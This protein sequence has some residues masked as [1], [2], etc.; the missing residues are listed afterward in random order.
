[1]EFRIIPISTNGTGVAAVIAPLAIDNI[2]TVANEYLFYYGSTGFDGSATSPSSNDYNAIAT[3]KTALMPGNTGSFNNVSS[4]YDGIN[5]ILVDFS[6]LPSDASLSAADF[7]FNVDSLLAPNAW[8]AAPAPTSVVTWTGPNGDTFADM[9]WAN[10]V[11]QNQWLQVTVL[12]DGN[13]NLAANDVFYFGN[14]MGA[15]GATL[16]TNGN[17]TYLRVGPADVTGAELAVG[18]APV[19]ITSLYDYARAGRVSPGDVSFV[20]ALVGPTGLLLISPAASQGQVAQGDTQSVAA[21]PS[22]AGPGDIQA[23]ALSPAVSAAG[24]CIALAPTTTIVPPNSAA[25]GRP[26]IPIAANGSIAPIVS[27]Q[28]VSSTAPQLPGLA[29]PPQSTAKATKPTVLMQ[30][31]MGQAAPKSDMVVSA[32]RAAGHGRDARVTSTRPGGADSNLT[33]PKPTVS[34]SPARP[35]LKAAA[36]IQF[37]LAAPIVALVPAEASPWLQ[38]LSIVLGPVLD[39]KVL[40]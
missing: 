29:D 31:E 13:T 39:F 40:N 12:A 24:S 18:P 32:M 17:G 16:N 14:M 34:T 38:S 36:P 26:T 6:N 1:V 37:A 35:D 9:V 19:A 25:A 2:S 20:Q 5:G 7:Q 33:S 23:V 21:S 8:T 15:T 10:N 28:V 11:I 4:Y 22:Q 30:V 3:D 27:K